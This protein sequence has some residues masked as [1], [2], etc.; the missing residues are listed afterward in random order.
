[1]TAVDIKRIKSPDD[2]PAG[3]F[4]VKPSI[5]LSVNSDD[6][7]VQD[8]CLEVTMCLEGFGVKDKKKAPAKVEDGEKTF[9][10][11]VTAL[12]TFKPVHKLSSKYQPTEE[13]ASELFFVSH[14]LIMSK[15]KDYAADIGYRS[16]SPTLGV[17]YDELTVDNIERIQIPGH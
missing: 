7:E 11:S 4:K 16:V 15:L 8:F 13:L 10:I 6:D 17:A 3:R 14:P 12:A 5:L 1:M 9:S 2:Y